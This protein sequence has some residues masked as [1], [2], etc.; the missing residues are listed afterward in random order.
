MLSITLYHTGMISVTKYV[1]NDVIN[2]IALTFSTIFRV[3]IAKFFFCKWY[4][5]EDRIL[6]NTVEIRHT[7]TPPSLKF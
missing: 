7:P 4:K 1:D 3:G 2:T 5:K 6:G